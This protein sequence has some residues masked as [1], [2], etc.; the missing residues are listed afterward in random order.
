MQVYLVD[1]IYFVSCLIYRATQFADGQEDD[2]YV[3]NFDSAL[4]VCGDEQSATYFGTSQVEVT[5]FNETN[6][7]MFGAIGFLEGLRVNTL[8]EIFVEKESS[9]RYEMVMSHEIC[10]LCDELDREEG[11]YYKCLK[12]FDFPKKC[13]L[14]PGDYSI[15]NFV[16]D[17]EYLPVNKGTAGRYQVTQ[18]YSSTESNCIGAKTFVGCLKVDLVIEPK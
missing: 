13:P 6:A 15:N 16:L 14:R 5:R 10:N 12:N 4:Y 1:F 18:F 11:K 8:V 9:G 7:Y 3:L 2:D 17:T